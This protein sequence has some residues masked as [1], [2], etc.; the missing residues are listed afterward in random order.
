M[1]VRRVLAVA[2]GVLGFLVGVAL[3]FGAIWLLYLGVS[4][5]TTDQQQSHTCDQKPE[6]M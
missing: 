6:Q 3:M 4:S 1:K 5:V 2:F